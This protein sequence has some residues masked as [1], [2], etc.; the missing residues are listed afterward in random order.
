MK[1]TSSFFICDILQDMWL[2]GLDILLSCPLYHVE[3]ERI[4]VYI[5]KSNLVSVVWNLFLSTF[6]A[7]EYPP[8]C[9]FCM[10]LNY[11]MVCQ[12]SRQW[13]IYQIHYSLTCVYLYCNSITSAMV[14]VGLCIGNWYVLCVGTKLFVPD[15]KI[16]SRGARITGYRGYQK[17]LTGYRMNLKST[18]HRQISALGS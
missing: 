17:I 1:L 11:T 9:V 4:H 16:F 7:D 12:L 14:F 15:S 18:V 8:S 10:S 6:F 13:N 3:H 2:R 5:C